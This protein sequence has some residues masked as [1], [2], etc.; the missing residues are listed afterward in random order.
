MD[1]RE[2]L[3]VMLVLLAASTPIFIIGVAVVIKRQLEHKQIMAAIQKGIP[4]SELR[5]LRQKQNGPAWTWIR[6]ITVGIVLI[7]IGLAFIVAGPMVGVAHRLFVGLVLCGIGI[8]SVVRGV[9]QR[10]Y[11]PQS[12]PQA[13]SNAGQ[14]KT[15]DGVSTPG[16][17]RPD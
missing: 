3:G 12:Q 1:P 10:K 14:D 15:L 17:L 16:T 13:I 5:P 11:E 9:L 7:V 2:A 4:L 8:A 6:R